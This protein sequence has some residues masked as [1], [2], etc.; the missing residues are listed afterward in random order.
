MK[1]LLTTILMAIVAL[2]CAQSG[3]DTFVV[4]K[5]IEPGLYCFQRADVDSRYCL[6][7]VNEEKV[8][9]FNAEE[10]IKEICAIGEDIKRRMADSTQAFDCVIKGDK[11]VF[12]K[13]GVTDYLGPETKFAETFYC[14]KKGKELYVETQWVFYDVMGKVVETRNEDFVYQLVECEKVPPTNTKTKFGAQ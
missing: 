2:A 14:Q 3:E 1:Y 9:V 7:F 12:I 4:K 11:I 6:W 13:K 8:L 5:K 10:S